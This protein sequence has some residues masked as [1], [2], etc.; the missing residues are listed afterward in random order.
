MANIPKMPKRPNQSKNSWLRKTLFF[1]VIGFFV[2]SFIAV[3]F[4][5]DNL[6]SVA[7]SDVIRRAN[8]GEISKIEIQGS[9]IHVT[10]KGQDKA[11]EKSYKE[12]GSS[13]YEQGLK[14]GS[15]E[16]TVKPPSEAE[17]AMWNILSLV[18]PA[19]LIGGLIFFMF[20]QAQG[21][22]NQAMGFGKSKARLYGNE[23]SKVV[24][25][26]I[27]GNEEAKEDLTEVVDFLKHPK[28]FHDVGAKIPKG[29]LL[30]GPPGTGKTM[31]ARAVA[32]EA[33]V[34]FFSISGSEFV[35]MFVGVGASRVRDLFEKAKKNAPCI[36]FIDEI[37]A[38]GRRRGSGMGGGHDE[39][40]QTLNQI[41]VEM[42]GFEGG[43]NVIVLA[44]TNR[45]DVL[46]PALLRP[47]RFDRRTNI[48]LPERKDRESILNVHFKNKPMESSVDLDKLAA[49]TAGSSGADLANIANEAA[50][51]AARHN[52]K[53][54][55]NDDVTAAFEKVAIGPERKTKIM[56][57]K[58]KELT[59][60][61][62]AGHAIVGHVLPD[63][64]PVHKVTII[65]RGGT[66]GVTWFLPPEDRSYTSVV[67]F[68]DIL[69]RALGGRIAEKVVYGDDRITTGAGSD[70]RKATEIA[71]D[72]V[73]EQGMGNALRDQVFHEDNGGMMFDRMTHERPY[74]DDTARLID[75]EVEG[76]IK[77]AARRAEVVI[78]S[79]KK[80]LEALAKRLLKEETVDETVVVEVLK[81]AV[82]PKEAKLY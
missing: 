25:A 16:V 40:E 59:A 48:I 79:N 11:T 9:D 62:E 17:G 41:L 28:K 29:V 7:F 65:P 45:A 18:V 77:E 47:G 15:T 10:P 56:N 26:D 53:K 74:S 68:K 39:R 23:K 52:R 76:L 55:S 6:K 20:R 5:Q 24:F 57:E 8:N 38:V 78:T 66:G 82:L 37:D 46:D 1:A 67:E 27:A 21:Q 2:L 63:S 13:I 14:Q 30:V 61:H 35:E 36:I 22:S 4:P 19:L 54:I 60:Y 50:I 64:D 58:E 44:A 12:S 51:I 69:A 43:T 75:Q 32:G 31:L 71:R 3:L 49:K 72:M 33:E 42:D 80:P 34:P 81:D 73:I 70:L